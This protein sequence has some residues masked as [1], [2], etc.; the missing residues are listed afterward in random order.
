MGFNWVFKGL[1][2]M[3]GKF[4][5]VPTEDKGIQFLNFMS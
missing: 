1:T 4:Y 5:V 3:F 2:G